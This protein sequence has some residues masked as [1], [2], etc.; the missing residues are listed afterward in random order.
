MPLGL[1][2]HPQSVRDQAVHVVT[3]IR[4]CSNPASLRL[5]LF[6]ANAYRLTILFRGTMPPTQAR[7]SPT[8]RTS[9]TSVRRMPGALRD[10][11]Y[12]EL[13][14]LR[15]G[16][17]RFIHQSESWA[18]EAGLTPAQHQLLLAIRGHDARE[19]PTISDVAGYLLL[20]HHSVVELVDRA[21][22]ADLVSRH[23]DVRDARLVRLA[24]TKTGRAALER[25]SERN[26]D[27]LR[28]LAD[29]FRPLWHGIDQEHGTSHEDP[30][31][32]TAEQSKR[33]R[34]RG[35]ARSS[36]S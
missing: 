19:G 24:L 11:D 3:L 13:L 18:R 8:T 16:L 22:A 7:K 14:L 36:R 28:R 5:V 4:S 35:P 20:R 33:P 21:V 27:E 17:R 2:A 6:V 25:L 31:Q 26:L 12:R 10:E 23:E 34:A 15:T 9:M 29:H 32:S 30:E 1:R